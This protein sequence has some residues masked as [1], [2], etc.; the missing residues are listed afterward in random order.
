MICRFGGVLRYE[1]KQPT[2]RYLDLSRCC[3]VGD[4]AGLARYDEVYDPN[5]TEIRHALRVTVRATNGYVYP[6]SHRA[7]STPGALPTGARLRLKA[8]VDI[9]QRTS[10]PNIRKIFRAMQRY[11][12]IVAVTA[13]ICTSQEPTTHVGI[14]EFSI[15]PSLP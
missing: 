2:P 11:G 6:A 5:V 15:Q 9:N 10:D 4:F 13:R 7:G 14:T 1:H 3:G 12:L 8:T